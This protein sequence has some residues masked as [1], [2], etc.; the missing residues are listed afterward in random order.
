MTD[1]PSNA[2]SHPAGVPELFSRDPWRTDA[3]D[4]FVGSCLTSGGIWSHPRTSDG[5]PSIERV[6]ERGPMSDTYG[7]L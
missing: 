2:A 1:E 3:L 6:F 5:I 7:M 4:G